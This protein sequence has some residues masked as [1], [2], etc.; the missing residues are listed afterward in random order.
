MYKIHVSLG[1]VVNTLDENQPGNLRASTRSVSVATDRQPTEERSVV[2]EP[3]IPEEEE[4]EQTV[5][6]KKELDSIMDDGA[7]EDSDV[8]RQ[9]SL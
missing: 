3:E 9:S 6:L 4:E 1:K 8:T 5:V 2:G 7:S